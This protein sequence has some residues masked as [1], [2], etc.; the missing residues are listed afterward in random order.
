MLSNEFKPR[1]APL[2]HEQPPAPHHLLDHSDIVMEVLEEYLQEH[3][4]ILAEPD[5]EEII[6]Q[7]LVQLFCPTLENCCFTK[8]KKQKRGVAE[9]IEGDMDD[10]HI[11]EQIEEAIQHFFTFVIPRRS[12]QTSFTFLPPNVEKI[13]AQLDHLRNKPQPVQR[14]EEWYQFRHNLITASELSKVFETQSQQNNLIY[15][16]CKPWEPM[17]R[18]NNPAS[19]LHWGQK[20][21]PLSVM[22]YEH[23]Y[24][25]K[26]GE[27]GCIQHETLPFLG[28]S[29][30]GINIDPSSPR[31]GR[32]LEIKN[33]LSREIDGI[34]LKEYWIQMQAQMEVC[35]LDECDFLETKFVEYDGYREYI[36]DKFVQGSVIEDNNDRD[37]QPKEEGKKEGEEEEE[38][39]HTFS[40][41][42]KFKGCVMMF[43][44]PNTNT[45]V[46]EFKPLMLNDDDEETVW[47]E[48]TIRRYELKG[49]QWITNI[50]WKLQV[51]S[52]V[53]VLRNRFWFQASVP[54]IRDMW[55]TIERERLA[56]YDHRAP[57]SRSKKIEVK[58]LG[59]AGDESVTSSGGEPLANETSDEREA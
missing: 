41:P 9:N 15:S 51:F 20:Y 12:F 29:P 28:A 13:Q 49:Y 18:C 2:S 21:E 42:Y 37:N 10:Q 36:A 6:T 33:V 59:G 54:Q 16:K 11:E 25:T 52:C 5:A 40:C 44:L 50:Y 27:F 3:F 1:Y 30:D 48:E 56:G 7:D 4:S 35:N 17:G 47:E 26:V 22:L 39:E 46:Y 23:I 58:L 14:T 19:P 57:K 55:D 34:P 53:L 45:P 8:K 38:E 24:Q 43:M 31:F 32:L